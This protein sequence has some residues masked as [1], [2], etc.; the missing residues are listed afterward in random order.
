M[1]NL[2]E[3][4]AKVIKLTPIKTRSGFDAL[5]TFE[6][7][8]PRIIL[9]EFNT[10]RAFSRN[11]ASSRAIPAKKMIESVATDPF[12]PVA[13]MKSHKGM[14]GFDYHEETDMI[15]YCRSK[16]LSAKEHAVKAAI[17]LNEQ[18]VSKQIVNRLLEPFMWHKV[19]MTTSLRGF[20]HFFQLR[21]NIMAEIHMQILAEAMMDAY[22][23]A[24][25]KASW[26]EIG[27]PVGAVSGQWHIPYSEDLSDLSLNEKLLVSIARCARVSY[28]TVGD[29]STKSIDEDIKLAKRLF[30]SKHM[31]PFEHIAQIQVDWN[32]RNFTNCIQL[33]EMIETNEIVLF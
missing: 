6:L 12:I 4:S 9:A 8:M 5:I 15:N 19:I 31:S 16:W 18:Q 21:A 33:R 2:T 13:W 10:H 24:Y 27:S 3:I 7:I 25:N 32:S 11:S 23:I 26:N 1:N 30:E 14:Q 29:D 28:T 20:E 17:D 22:E